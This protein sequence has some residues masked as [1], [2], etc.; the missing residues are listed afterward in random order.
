MYK[1][2]RKSKRVR[3]KGGST[4]R[5][6]TR[7]RSRSRSR[8][9]QLSATRSSQSSIPRYPPRGT[10]ASSSRTLKTHNKKKSEFLPSLFL[11]GMYANCF[12]YINLAVLE[13][14]F[15]LYTEKKITTTKIV[16]IDDDQTLI[17]NKKYHNTLCFKGE[18]KAGHYVFVHKVKNKPAQIYG[19]YERNILADN[20]DG[21]CHLYALFMSMNFSDTGFKPTLT[22]PVASMPYHTRMGR[23]RSNITMDDFI[24]GTINVCYLDNYYLI[25]SFCYDILCKPEW[26]TIL[27]AHFGSEFTIQERV[28]KINKAKT[29]LEGWYKTHEPEL[30]ASGIITRI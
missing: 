11:K 8:S 7:L 22:P 18:N 24:D 23:F 15:F 9:P 19:T 13:D 26:G 6:S 20:D 3:V 10:I 27:D 21:L 30:I 17:D 2:K 1:V 5:S 16:D 14:L 4:R 28:S 29:L 12:Q 25:F